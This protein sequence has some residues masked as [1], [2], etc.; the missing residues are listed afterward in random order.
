MYT[1][2]LNTAAAV[3]LCALIAGCAAPVR[4]E[5]PEPIV[6]PLRS[7]QA[8]PDAPFEGELQPYV[9]FALRHHPELRAEHSRWQ[10]ESAQV[11]AAYVWPEPTL[12]YGFFLRSVETRVGPQ[13][14]R[15]GLQQMIP[16]PTKPGVAAEIAAA[17]ADAQRSRFN[18]A[19]LAVRRRVADAYWRRWQL[20]QQQYW[21]EQQLVLVESIEIAARAAVEVGRSPQSDLNQLSLEITRLRDDI[22]Q[23][24]SARNAARAR[25][26]ETLGLG[27]V[28]DVPVNPDQEPQAA[29]PEADVEQLVGWAK[30]HPQLD[31]IQKAMRAEQRA[32]ERARLD[33]YPDF[34]VGVD[35]IETGEAMN[36]DV[37]DSGKDPIIAM[38]GI[39]IPLFFERYAAQVE[40]SQARGEARAA[41]LEAARNRA[42]ADVRALLAEL[43]DSA[44]RIRLYQST[45]IPQADA[46]YDSVVG[47]YEVGQTT[48]ASVLLAQRELLRLR[49]QMAQARAEHA[50][51]WA[52]LEQIVGRPVPARRNSQ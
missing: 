43:D 21:V 34:S 32:A 20:A 9:D 41:D 36:P 2:C 40:A 29:A 46:T 48:I 14:H 47:R 45:L 49:L 35:Y 52:K 3:S 22:E 1:K 42:A 44:R 15:F 8:A 51:S 37:E 5:A 17:R 30:A 28:A 38:V 24:R 12:T 33:R 7:A 26:V 16:W 13:R 11:D 6:G 4:V 10:A 31:A 19:M 25:F 23:L 18:A 50:R 39:K 27:E